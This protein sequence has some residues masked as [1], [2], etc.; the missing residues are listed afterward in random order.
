[1]PRLNW[2]ERESIFPFRPSWNFRSK[3][4]WEINR[5]GWRDLAWITREAETDPNKFI[6]VVGSFFWMH[7]CSFDGNGCIY[8]NEW[9]PWTRLC[10]EILPVISAEANGS[11][12][13]RNLLLFKGKFSAGISSFLLGIVIAQALIYPDKYWKSFRLLLCVVSSNF[14][15]S[16]PSPSLFL[17]HLSFRDLPWDSMKTD[18]AENIL[19]SSNFLP[20]F[21]QHFS[22]VGNGTTH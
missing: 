11:R 22:S 12:K 5:N 15:S 3:L 19:V 9:F 16:F 6:P 14:S 18:R 1:M 13:K 8:Q 10:F 20:N 7:F 4:R 17:S 21:I 2:S